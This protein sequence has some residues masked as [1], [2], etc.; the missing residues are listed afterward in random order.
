MKK[1][2]AILT[3]VLMLVIPLAMSD[4][5]DMTVTVGNVAPSVDN[6]VIDGED[7]L[8]SVDPTTGATTSV[9][10]Y[11][12][13]TDD[14]GW[15]D[16][17]T[18]ICTI[19]GPG[20]VQDSPV[21]L[22]LS[23]LDS[24]TA[25]G[26]ESFD[27][28]FYDASGTYTVDCEATDASALTGDRQENFDY[29]SLTALELDATAVAFPG[30]DPGVTTTVDGDTNM[31][32]PAAPTIQNYGNVEIDATISGTDLISGANTITVGNVRYEFDTLGL[33]TLSGTTTPVDINLTAGA[34]S[35][36]NI[37]FE[38]DVP[39]ATVSGTYSGTTTILATSS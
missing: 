34:S 26:S 4:S 15:D 1:T 23:E 32:T 37:D 36:T 17:S 39:I 2:I 22:I 35:T 20:T 5:A 6:I 11:A 29:T 38:L 25:E 12:E 8:A 27:M 9:T 30:V 19:T 13:A 21:T 16:V 18:I 31:G 10:L 3:A 33:T 7:T 24:D 28:D 14:N